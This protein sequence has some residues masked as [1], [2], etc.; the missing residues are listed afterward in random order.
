VLA[1]PGG[2]VVTDPV[3]LIEILSPSG[4]ALTRKNVRAYSTVPSVAE[5]LLLGGVRT[6]AELLRRGRDEGWPEA[7]VS[8]GAEDDLELASIG[9][10]APLRGFYR[11]TDLLTRR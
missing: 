10:R 1:A 7:P 4:E 2:Q 9:F 5:V 6:E 3:L 11:T 8:L